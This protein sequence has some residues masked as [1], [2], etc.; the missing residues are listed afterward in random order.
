[1]LSIGAIA[2]VC[3]LERVFLKLGLPR[4]E[5]EA[6]KKRS[7]LRLQDAVSSRSRAGSLGLGRTVQHEVD[8]ELS[9]HEVGAQLVHCC[10]LV[11]KKWSVPGA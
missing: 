11:V 1:M 7:S 2:I 9:P 3:Y 4:L 5:I 8:Q 6:V 10:I